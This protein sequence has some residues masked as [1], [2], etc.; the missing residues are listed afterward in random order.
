MEDG[1]SNN[2]VD[3]ASVFNHVC[4]LLSVNTSIGVTSN[5]PKSCIYR[6]RK[7]PTIPVVSAGH[8]KNSSHSTPVSSTNPTPNTTA[9]NSPNRRVTSISENDNTNVV[10]R[11]DL[12]TGIQK[13]PTISA[14]LMPSSKE[15]VSKMSK[16]GIVPKSK[17]VN[18][19]SI[20]YVTVT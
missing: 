2:H 7:E 3:V 13:I 17:F 1:S 5:E 9:P 8:E 10:A 14:K 20:V 19:T 6:S 18:R 4:Q 16:I 12:S 15:R 11:V